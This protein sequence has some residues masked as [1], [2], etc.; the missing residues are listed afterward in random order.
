MLSEDSQRRLEALERARAIFP[1]SGELTYRA[2]Q[3][4]RFQDRPDEAIPLF[5]KLLR[6]GWRPDWSPTREEL[7][8]SQLLAGRLDDVLRTAAEGEQR[9]PTRYKYPLYA[10]L[11]LQQSGRQPEAREALLR[12]IRKHLDFSAAGALGVRQTAQY[13]AS[14]LRWDEERRR[15]W[16]AALAEAERGL[17]SDP[18]DADLGVARADALVGLGRFEEARSALERV[19]GPAGADPAS[20]LALARACGGLGDAGCARAALERAAG[21]WRAGGVP[22]LGTLAYNIA[23]AWSGLG[24]TRQAYEWLLRARDQYGA[25]RL[26]IAMDPDLDA[27]RRAG[28]LDKLP[29]RR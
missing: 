18:N 7:A 4:Y 29:P 14:L 28:L 13:W 6:S 9:F 27:L 22:A 25:D 16:Q 3:A 24:D 8:L 26:D 1:E 20:F 19:A 10:A 21:I 15:Q 23:A 12:A 17:A 2:G 5:E 11:A